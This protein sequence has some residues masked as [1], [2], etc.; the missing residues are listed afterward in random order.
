VRSCDGLTTHHIVAMVG[1][2]PAGR[3]PSLRQPAQLPHHAGAQGFCDGGSAP[4]SSPQETEA[5]RRA[6]Q[7]AEELRALGRELADVA[8]VR[9]FNPRERYKVGEVVWHQSLAAA[10][11]RRFCAQACWFAC[12]RRDESVMLS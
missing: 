7:K 10:R 9:T 2:H 3:V 12:Q 4:A 8:D 6:E 11:W 1:R 5:A